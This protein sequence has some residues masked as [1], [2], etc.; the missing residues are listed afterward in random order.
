[1]LQYEPS[2]NS[3]SL[4][5]SP[6]EVS[7]YYPE[8]LSYIATLAR[9]VDHSRLE[10]AF[11]AVERLLGGLDEGERPLAAR[12]PEVVVIDGPEHDSA[13]ALL[14]DVVR[15]LPNHVLVVVA[16]PEAALVSVGTHFAG[17]GRHDL[18]PMA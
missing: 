12:T 2:I 15:L 14:H 17:I 4:D 9:H 6:Y 5:T 7:E 1:M 16:D 8:W 10:G 13:H 3:I 11:L 18:G